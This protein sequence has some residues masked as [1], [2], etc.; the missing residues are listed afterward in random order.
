MKIT[1]VKTKIIAISL[2][3]IM[4]STIVLL[5]ACEWVFGGQPCPIERIERRMEI[6]LPENIEILHNYMPMSLQDR[7]PQYTLFL[8]RESPDKFLTN[9]GFEQGLKP[10]QIFDSN[11]LHQIYQRKRYVDGERVPAVPEEFHPPW[12]EEFYWTGEFP[13]FLIFFPCHLWLIYIQ[14]FG[15]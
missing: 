11:S 13:R 2:V 7:P 3:A 1:K 5:S 12:G 9:S 15:T 10:S 8:L 6:E 4:L 14:I